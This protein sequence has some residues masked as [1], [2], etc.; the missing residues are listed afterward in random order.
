MHTI[1]ILRGSVAPEII[2]QLPECSMHAFEL[3]AA[4]GNYRYQ[5]I[6]DYEIDD[7]GITLAIA[8]SRYEMEILRIA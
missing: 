2:G 7:G 1:Q 6:I 5:S 8:K 4:A 3:W